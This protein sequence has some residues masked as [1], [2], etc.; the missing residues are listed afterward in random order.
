MVQS[1][2]WEGN[3]SSGNQEILRILWNPKVHDHI[4]KNRPPVPMPSHS[5]LVH[6]HPIHADPF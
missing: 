3:R 5:N 6:L 1:R 4:H 2:S